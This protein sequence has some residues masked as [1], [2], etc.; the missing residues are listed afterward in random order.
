MKDFEIVDGEVFIDKDL[1]W[2]AWDDGS[3]LSDL[4][5]DSVVGLFSIKPTIRTGP[6]SVIIDYHNADIVGVHQDYATYFEDIRD[7]YRNNVRG[8]VT[9]MVDNQLV[10]VT[11]NN[12]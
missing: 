1:F 12:Y 5:G 6:E 7:K 2:Q 4:T 9:I 10:H 8:T 11:I 3:A